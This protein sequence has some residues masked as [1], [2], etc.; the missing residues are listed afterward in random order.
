MTTTAE[1]IKPKAHL[2]PDKIPRVKRGPLGLLLWFQEMTRRYGDHPRFLAECRPVLEKAGIEPDDVSEAVLT[3][4]TRECLPLAKEQAERHNAAEARGEAVGV[5]RIEDEYWLTGRH[6]DP[7]IRRQKA[8]AV[9]K[10]QQRVEAQASEPYN[11]ETSPEPNTPPEQETE[12]MSE[13]APETK[14][15][16]VSQSAAVALLKDLGFHLAEKFTPAKLREKMQQLGKSGPDD[17]AEPNEASQKLLKK[18]AVAANDGA[19]IEITGGDKIAPAASKNGSPKKGKAGKKKGKD[20]CNKPAAAESAAEPDFG[21]DADAE[22]ES[23]AALD[24]EQK[25]QSED[26]KPAKAKSKK[27]KPKKAG[28][29]AKDTGEKKGMSLLDAAVKVLGQTKKPL[30]SKEI[31]EKATEK[32]YWVPGAGLTPWDTVKAAMLTE[33][34]KKGKES[35]FAKPKPG[36]YTLAGK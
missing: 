3:Q 17:T 5:I 23:R 19:E 26:E 15:V 34:A 2:P 10:I 35:R 11:D 6:S 36:K 9:E 16:K 28:K 29:P 24:A 31:V 1:P 20:K 8:A 27:D 33:I 13:T 25:R 12:S 7:A 32:G 4:A 22:D 30:T 21:P 14:T 18:L